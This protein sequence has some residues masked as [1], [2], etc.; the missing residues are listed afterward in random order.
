MSHADEMSVDGRPVKEEVATPTAMGPED[1]G[2][3]TADERELPRLPPHSHFHPSHA[4]GTGTKRKRATSINEDQDPDPEL[5][6]EPRPRPSASDGSPPTHVVWTRAFPKISASALEA[7]TGHKNASTFA[8]PVKERDAPGY[9]N[10]I[11]RPQDLKS[12][13]SAISHGHKAATTLCP[14]DANPNASSVML[15]IHEDIIPPK[16]IINYPQ[17]EKELMRMFANAVMFN[18]DPD[19]GFGRRWRGAG[20]GVHGEDPLGYEIDEDGVVKDTK[21]MFADVEKIVGSLRSAERRSEEIAGFG[22]FGGSVREREKEK[23]RESSVARAST[24][25]DDEDDDATADGESHTGTI[26]RR[27]KV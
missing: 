7:I 24:R 16:G 9:K 1:T 21:H 22:G 5:D 23:D 12:I 8:I 6:D 10:L 17:L 18:A 11:L 2:D 20:S 15:P 26:K 14:A 13:R 19:R 3:T 25:A 4:P 27:K